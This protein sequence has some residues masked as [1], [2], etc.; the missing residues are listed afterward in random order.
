[1]GLD[2]PGSVTASLPP[3]GLARPTRMSS[4]LPGW[5]KCMNIHDLTPVHSVCTLQDLLKDLPKCMSASLVPA[6]QDVVNLTEVVP[7]L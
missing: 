4:G 6:Q 3:G 2:P 1:M 5:S 7:L